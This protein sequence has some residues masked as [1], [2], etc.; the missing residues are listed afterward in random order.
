MKN[1]LK[2]V[3]N[4]EKIESDILVLKDKAEEGVY[5]NYGES[6]E[7]GDA[8]LTVEEYNKNVDEFLE[9]FRNAVKDLNKIIENF[10]KKK[11]GT[12]NGRN[13]RELASCNNCIAIHEWHNT[14][15]Y[16]IVKVYADDDTTLKV[17]FDEKVDTPA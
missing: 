8:T 9:D 16:K 12:F 1:N 6:Q 7:F 13:V 3:I 15:I 11:N 5:V 2:L 17:V 14:W 10:P 4:I